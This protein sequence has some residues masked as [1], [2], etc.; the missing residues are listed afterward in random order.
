MHQDDFV[1]I[2]ARDEEKDMAVLNMCKD[3][4]RPDL[5]FQKPGKQG[6]K[7]SYGQRNKQFSQQNKFGSK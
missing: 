6:P 4:F 2:S 3:K 5:V 1:E 7:T